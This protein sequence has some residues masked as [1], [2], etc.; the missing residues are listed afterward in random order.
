MPM[1]ALVCFCSLV[2][3]QSECTATTETLKQNSV[4]SVAGHRSS[5]RNHSATSESGGTA[6]QISGVQNPRSSIC[7]S[8][9]SGGIR[10]EDGPA[11]QTTGRLASKNQ[12]QNSSRS[13]E[14]TKKSSQT[15]GPPHMVDPHLS[16]KATN[17]YSRGTTGAISR[18]HR[19]S[20]MD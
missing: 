18:R 8:V 2:R 1:A 13:S 17:R 4:A 15:H 16:N 3:V 12:L 6:P 19:S 14:K 7:H 5:A 20:R 11:Q 10:D 9:C